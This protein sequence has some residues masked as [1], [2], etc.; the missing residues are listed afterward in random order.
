MTKVTLP[1]A[2]PTILPTSASEILFACAENL[3]ARAAN[4]PAVGEDV[5]EGE[6]EGVGDEIEAVVSCWT[7]C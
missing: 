6:D 7:I 2:L 5:V 4:P 1:M 3:S